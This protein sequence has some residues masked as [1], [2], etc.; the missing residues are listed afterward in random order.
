MIGLLL[1]L[2]LT[3]NMATRTRLLLALLTLIILN[4][5]TLL[6]LFFHGQ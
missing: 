6:A 1:V 4:G 2:S 5:P 3:R